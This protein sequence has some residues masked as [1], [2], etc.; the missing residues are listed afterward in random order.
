M[1]VKTVHSG[2]RALMLASLLSGISALP[3][4]A[5][6]TWLELTS[7]TLVGRLPGEA[8]ARPLSRTT[9]SSLPMTWHVVIEG[10]AAG[11]LPTYFTDA[12]AIDLGRGVIPTEQL[13]KWDPKSDGEFS[14]TW[15]QLEPEA[16][17]YNNLVPNFH[18]EPIVWKEVLL[19]AL[20]GQWSWQATVHPTLLPDQAA[21]LATGVGIARYKVRFKHQEYTLETPGAEGAFPGGLGADAFWTAYRGPDAHP[22]VS[23]AFSRFNMPYVAGAS[24]TGKGDE[25]HQALLGYGTDSVELLTA[26]WR[27]AGH[28]EVDF[29]G[30]FQL[31]PTH[32]VASTVQLARVRPDGDRYIDQAGEP[33]L[34]GP[35]LL[36]P[37]DLLRSGD[38]AGIFARDLPPTGLLDAND[39]VVSA[40]FHEPKLQPLRD[41]L[42]GPLTL[43][44]WND[45]REVQYDLKLLKFFKGKVDGKVSPELLAAL[46]VFRQE[47]Q[48]PLLSDEELTQSLGARGGSA[49][50]LPP[51]ALFPML[52]TG[53]FSGLEERE[54]QPL[55]QRMFQRA[56]FLAGA[57]GEEAMTFDAPRPLMDAD[58]LQR[59]PRE[60]YRVS[61]LSFWELNDLDGLAQ[62]F[63]I[64]DVNRDGK[65][66]ALEA[67]VAVRTPGPALVLAVEK[68]FKRRG[69]DP[70]AASYGNLVWLWLPREELV[71]VY[72][73]L[74]EVKVEA[75]AVL[76]SGTPLGTIGRTGKRLKS[77]NAQTALAVAGFRAEG[78][79]L[80][81]TDL[82]AWWGR[83]LPAH[84]F[85]AYTPH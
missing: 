70:L 67:P 21:E 78:G 32:E 11:R 17:S 58:D 76:A 54:L 25:T 12:P 69:A 10:R 50:L 23:Y 73:H 49:R 30:Q 47:A 33:V 40:L 44:R 18:L 27:L 83:T 22:L 39:L 42:H 45:V 71:L 60:P 19:P 34:V 28:P 6:A 80:L 37:G 38:E 56:S 7:L 4:T 24:R 52:R 75:G 57:R 2:G 9:S 31:D 81:P 41:S 13:R 43:L 64:A 61:D 1:R 77:R 74:G 53:A 79:K 46:R 16:K 5:H 59:K 35:S 3:S 15:S 84:P 14:L 66:D 48:Q 82:A 65:L 85:P 20:Q 68:D 72:A 63:P 51:H 55:V 36:M 62:T 26:A 29:V 8:V